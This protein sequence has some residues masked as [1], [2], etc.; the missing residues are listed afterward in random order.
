MI[1]NAVWIGNKLSIVQRLCLSSWLA[2]GHKVRLWVYEDVENV[3]AGVDISGA[4]EVLPPPIHRYK[5]QGNFDSP[6]LHANLFRYLF[7]SLRGGVFIDTDTLCLSSEDLPQN[8][9]STE[10]ETKRIPN[11]AI[12]HFEAQHPVISWCSVEAFSRLDEPRAGRF[13][14]KLLSEGFERHF[15]DIERLPPSAFCPIPWSRA[16]RILDPEPPSL[17]G[18]KG[19]HLWDRVIVKSGLDLEAE[20]PPTC[21]WETWKR[22]YLA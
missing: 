12:V 10:H 21:L 11:F 22:D 17:E 6:V 2:H 4:E 14:P 8:T 1:V 15:N 3:P 18:A 7:L 9:V 13:G 16:W 20:H 5:D 19:V